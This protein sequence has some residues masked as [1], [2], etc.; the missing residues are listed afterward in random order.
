MTGWLPNIW[1]CNSVFNSPDTDMSITWRWYVY[2]WHLIPKYL[3]CYHLTLDPWHLIS[4]TGTSYYHLIP[5]T[6]HLIFDTWQLTC[7]HL[8]VMLSPDTST[9]DLILWHLTD[10]YTWHLYCIFMIITFTGTWHNYYTVTRHLVLLNSCAPE[11][12]Y[13]WTPVKGRL[14]ILYSC[15]SP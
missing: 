15:W 13:S 2:T 5:D 4:D 6:W 12:L 10:T 8:L 1:Y 14:L 9:L 7:Y 11:L 3:T